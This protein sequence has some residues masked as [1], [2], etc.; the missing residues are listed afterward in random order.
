MIDF[1]DT[2]Y[3]YSSFARLVLATAM[4]FNIVLEFPNLVEIYHYPDFVYGDRFLGLTTWIREYIYLFFSVY[5][6]LLLLFILGVG[7]Y[8]IP[9]LVLAFHS[10]TMVL[11]L[12]VVS[13]GENIQAL[14][15]LYFCFVDSYRYFSLFKT[16][17][18]PDVLSKWA[19]YAIMAHIAY[20]FLANASHKLQTPEWTQ[21][22]AAGYLFDSARPLDIFNIGSMLIEKEWLIKTGTYAVLAIQA[23]FPIAIWF[24]KTRTI[25]VVLIIVLHLGMGLIIQQFLFQL[26]VILHLGFFY[27]DKELLKTQF[28]SK[29]AKYG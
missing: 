14:F 19:T 11:H 22:L 18:E 5:L 29:F 12:P 6:F 7:R 25:F 24:R 15:L 9:F 28:F 23:L 4:I 17:G 16:K 8:V 27:S 1:K 2:R 10:I 21:G 20:I 13:W 26:A 3:I